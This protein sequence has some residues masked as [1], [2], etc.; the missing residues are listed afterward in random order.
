MS[1]QTHFKRGQVTWALWGLFSGRPPNHDADEIPGG[2][3]TYIKRLLERDWSN[4]PNS[5]TGAYAFCSKA[6]GSGVEAKFTVRDAYRLGVALE[7][8]DSDFGVADVVHL[9]RHFRP[10]L[11]GEYSYSTQV[12]LPEPVQTAHV[13]LDLI[14]R[15]TRNPQEVDMRSFLILQRLSLRESYPPFRSDIEI[16]TVSVARPTVCRGIQ[17]LNLA[18]ENLGYENRKVLIF[19]LSTIAQDVTTYLQCAPEFKRGPQ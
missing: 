19:E 4:R 12:L 11:D 7:M 3:Q 16:Q 14:T 1:T 10:L 17:S 18:L 6:G 5:R 2:F 9:V 15:T 8:V 13:G